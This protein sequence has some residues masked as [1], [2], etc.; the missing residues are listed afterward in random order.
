[1]NQWTKI[2]RG[3]EFGITLLHRTSSSRLVSTPS[4]SITFAITWHLS[5]ARYS[6]SMLG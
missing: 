4:M 2:V 5:A 1:V 6:Y 3:H